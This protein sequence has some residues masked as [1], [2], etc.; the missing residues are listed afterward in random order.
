MLR[1]MSTAVLMIGDNDDHEDEYDNHVF[2]ADSTWRPNTRALATRLSSWRARSS[3]PST[4]SNTITLVNILLLVEQYRHVITYLLLQVA[5]AKR[6]AEESDAKCEE[7]VRKLVREERAAKNVSLLESPNGEFGFSKQVIKNQ[8]NLLSNRQFVN[9]F[10][11]G[12]TKS[13]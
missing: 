6:I 5:E 1:V 2:L 7:I 12:Q 4:T 3:S 13:N 10:T 9:V 8:N 11:D